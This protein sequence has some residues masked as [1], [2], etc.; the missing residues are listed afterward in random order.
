MC[1]SCLLWQVVFIGVFLLTKSGAPASSEEAADKLDDVQLAENP[2]YE[3]GGPHDGQPSPGGSPGPHG[4]VAV[5]EDPDVPQKHKISMDTLRFTSKHEPM[6][7]DLQ[8]APP[9]AASALT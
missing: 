4:A 6:M 1:C 3:E 9:A 8:A 2:A 7:L 5:T